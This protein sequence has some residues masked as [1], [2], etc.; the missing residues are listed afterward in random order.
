[1]Q[2]K[3]L[4]VELHGQVWDELYSGSEKVALGQSLEAAH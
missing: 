3:S 2:Q 4:V 1:M